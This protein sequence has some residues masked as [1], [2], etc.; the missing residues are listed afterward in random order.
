MTLK[1]NKEVTCAAG[2]TQP[3][4]PILHV[5]HTILQDTFT[6]FLPYGQ[7]SVETA[8]YWFGIEIDTN[9]IVTTLVIPRLYQT[10]GNYRIDTVS[11]RRLANEMSEQ[12]LVNL[13]QVH[14]HPPGCSVEHSLYDDQHA[15]STRE[16]ALSFVWPSYGRS[17]SYDLR[18]VGV[19][20]RRE[21]RWILLTRSQVTERVRL[22]NSVVDYRWE[23]EHG[24]IEENNDKGKHF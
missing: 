18:S 14:T 8:C 3:P 7:A 19:H 15:Y 1:Q 24:N 23:I 20:E 11:S 22:L 12:G 10:K 17:A 9:Q 5:P 2:L 16:Y 21:G 4:L 13:A 6:Y